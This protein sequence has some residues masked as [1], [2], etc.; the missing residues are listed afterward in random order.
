MIPLIRGLVWLARALGPDRATA[1]GAALL[2]T[3]GPLL[4]AHRTAMANLRGAFPDMPEAER[5][6]IALEAWDNLGRTG[7]EYAHLDALFDFDPDSTE[8][9][10]TEVAGIEHFATLRDDGQPGLIFSAHLANWELPAICAAKFGWTRPRCSGRRTIPPP[11]GSSRRSAVA[12]W[13]ASPPP[14]P[15]PSSPCATW[16]RMAAISAS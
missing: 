11:P 16:S 3:V 4:P 5:K 12:P 8:P 14:R 13:A 6:R 10:R 15:A 7:A 2:R 1:F 9:M